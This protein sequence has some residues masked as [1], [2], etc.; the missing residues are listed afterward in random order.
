MTAGPVERVPTP[1]RAAPLRRKPVEAREP[2]EKAV[3]AHKA[4]LR[5]VAPGIQAA[6]ERAAP[7][8]AVGPA[9]PEVT[10]VKAPMTAGEVARVKEG[11]AA[12]VKAD[13]AARVRRPAGA[14]V[15][16]EPWPVAAAEE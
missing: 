10:V 6:K 4:A 5:T 8:R 15:S 3:L 11:R 1:A 13:R 2:P 9:T 14:A 12:R 7:T 16:P